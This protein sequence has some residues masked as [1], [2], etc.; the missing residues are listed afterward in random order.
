MKAD[1]DVIVVI[2]SILA[3][4][5]DMRTPIAW[6]NINEV[7]VEVVAKHLFEREE[8][9]DCYPTWESLLLDSRQESCA[10]AWRK[11]ARGI[12]QALAPVSAGRI[13]QG[14]VDRLRG[15]RAAIAEPRRQ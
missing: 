12:V 11:Q 1:V 2:D 15:V 8:A 7:C 3:E 9:D 4:A 6:I 10:K 5:G 14:W 13:V